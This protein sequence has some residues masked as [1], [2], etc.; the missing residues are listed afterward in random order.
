MRKFNLNKIAIGVKW[1]PHLEELRMREIKKVILHCSAS[2][3]PEH[4]NV[5][6]IRKWHVEENGWKDIGYHFVITR[7]GDVHKCRDIKDVGAHCIGHNLD[8]VGICL[9]GETEFTPDQYFSLAW[10]L[11][12]VIND[13]PS[14]VEV[15]PHNY[16]NK[17]KDCPNFKLRIFDM[18]VGF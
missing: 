2:S 3:L 7:N 10:L 6:S 9:T 11:A 1:P 5:E 16:Y 12:D 15:K 14:I 13:N 18:R 4:D 17:E 8:S